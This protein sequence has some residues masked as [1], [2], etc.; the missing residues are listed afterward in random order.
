ILHY[1]G[2]LSREE[3]ARELSCRANT[4]GVRLHRGREM[5]AK[6]LAKRGVMLSGVIIGVLLTEVCRT[7]VT[8][9][10][11]SSTAQAAV[12]F[13]AG[14]TY[15]CGLVS[16]QIVALAQRASLALANA[17]IRFAA[18]LALL[19]GGAAAAGAQVVS[20]V[21]WGLPGGIK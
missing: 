11:V 16:P 3:M 15:A 12:L 19:A 8:E 20:H 18:S 5:L 21:G 9:R 2:G 17:K 7:I 1:Y 10:L 6:R 13:S 14:H 4:L